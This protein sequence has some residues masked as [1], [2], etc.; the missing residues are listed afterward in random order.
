VMRLGALAVSTRLTPLGIAMT[1]VAALALGVPRGSAAPTATPALPQARG[2]AASTPLLGLHV[3]G[4]RI[5]NS[6]NQ[7][8]RLI[9]FNNSGAEYACVEGWGIFDTPHPRSMSPS[10]VAAMASW[11]GANT[12]RIPLDEQCWLGIGGVKPRYG[13]RNYRTAIKKY[14]SELNHAGFAVILDLQGTAPRNEL[15]RNQEEMPDTHAVAFWH[16]VATDFGN[17]TS[18]LFD[19]F[20]EPWPDNDAASTRAW[21][22]WRDGGCRLRSQNG[23]ATY[24]AVGMNQLIADVRRTGARNIVLA[25]GL[26]YAESLGKWLKYEPHD[27]DRDLVASTHVY[28]FNNCSHLKCYNGPLAS[29]AKRVP[30][31]IGEFGPNLTVRYSGKL[32]SKCPSKDI[33]R[34]QFDRTLLDWADQHGVSWTSWSWNAWGDCW[35]LVKNFAGKPTTPYGKLVRARLLAERQKSPV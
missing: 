3:S 13:G 14:V 2:S 35:S 11:T 27:P 33:G 10:I 29:V 9:G 8:V 22:C 15:S 20:N 26:Q 34:T 1:L 23:K 28:S 4:N 12:V 17:N 7:V 31:V 24:T 32:D 16:Q 6:H 19:L 5:E 30:L 21:K 18:V 25:G